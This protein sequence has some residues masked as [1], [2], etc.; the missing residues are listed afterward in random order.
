[1]LIIDSMGP[2]AAPEVEF[3]R[4]PL[5]SSHADNTSSLKRKLAGLGSAMGEDRLRRQVLVGSGVVKG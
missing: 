2:H 5:K 1:M 3:I 4:H